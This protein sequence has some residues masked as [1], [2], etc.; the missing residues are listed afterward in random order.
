MR[1][2]IARDKDN[3]LWLYTDKPSKNGDEFSANAID[4]F[5]KIDDDFYP[6]VTWDNSP[7][8]LVTPIR[9]SDYYGE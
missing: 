2:W 5:Y 1:V 3:S 7:Q 8:E 6:E 4:G 9:H